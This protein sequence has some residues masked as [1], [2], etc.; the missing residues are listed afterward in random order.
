M[1]ERF[2]KIAPGLN[3]KLHF[4]VDIV[5]AMVGVEFSMDP[6]RHTA[7]LGLLCVSAAILWTLAASV[8]R[9]YSPSTPRRL[10]DNLTLRAIS[11]MVTV[12]GLWFMAWLTPGLDAQNV[13]L[14]NF[15]AFFF[16]TGGLGRMIAF[17]PLRRLAR[18]I[19]DVLIVGTGA[20]AQAT[21]KNLTLDGPERLSRVVGFLALADQPEAMEGVNLPVWGK[22]EQLLDVLQDH[23][24]SEV[25]LAGR[26]VDYAQEMQ[27]VVD[28]CE[29]VG[30][31]FALPLHSLH[32]ERAQLLSNSPARDG[33]LHY[34]STAQKPFQYALKRLMDIGASAAALLVL[35]PMLILV[36]II[37]KV[38]APGPVMF[39]QKRVGLHGVTFD[40]L[41]FRS[42]V[43]NAEAIKDS[44]MAANEQSG[45]VFKMENDPR[46]TGIGRFIRR[47]SIDE[48]PQLINILRGDMTIVGPRPAVPKE[49]VQYKAW[50][51]RRLSVRPGLTCYWQVGGRNAIGFEE[52][53]RLDLRYVDNWTIWVDFSLIAQTFPAVLAGRGAS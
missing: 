7:H 16:L 31:P 52:W 44:L 27:T 8:T 50:Q 51:R 20:M 23:P 26:I 39:T 38:T 36:A 35:S 19:Q 22:S 28:T 42:M 41:K 33:Y 6:T 32:F 18:P 46:I 21:Y 12:G 37:I 24:V 25:Y 15:G 11:V 53:M 3:N 48:L 14:R 13:L 10:G 47:F 1:N 17:R 43:V 2:D 34:M 9:I 29:R 40:L 5:L 30:M 4:A 45:P 49:V